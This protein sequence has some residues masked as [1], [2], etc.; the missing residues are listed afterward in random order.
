MFI[1]DIKNKTLTV[2]NVYKLQYNFTD[3]GAIKFYF[4]KFCFLKGQCHKIF[5]QFFG[6]KDSA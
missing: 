5:D 2:K 6:L 4:L 1:P 3:V